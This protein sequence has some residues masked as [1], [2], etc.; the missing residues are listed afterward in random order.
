[1]LCVHCSLIQQCVCFIR[2]L[3]RFQRKGSNN[4]R[5]NNHNCLHN[6]RHNN[7]NSN[8]HVLLLVNSLQSTMAT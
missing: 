4:S 2:G 1:V 7:N 5:N 6:N 3:L 8:N